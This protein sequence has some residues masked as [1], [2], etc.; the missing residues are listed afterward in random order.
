MAWQS[1]AEGNLKFSLPPFTHFPK[2]ANE[3]GSEIIVSKRKSQWDMDDQINCKQWQCCALRKIE[4]SPMPWTRVI[5]NILFSCISR[6]KV[7][8]HTEATRYCNSTVLSNGNDWSCGFML[9]SYM[10]SNVISDFVTSAPAPLMDK[11]PQRCKIN[12]CLI[13][14]NTVESPKIFQ[15]LI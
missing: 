14:H 11:N 2:D 9:C 12:H 15:E 3:S 7:R 13:G 5:Q 6:A 10:N 8:C 1:S 4:D